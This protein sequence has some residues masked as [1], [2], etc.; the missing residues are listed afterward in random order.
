MSN[1]ILKYLL[2]ICIPLLS[3][4]HTGDESLYSYHTQDKSHYSVDNQI[5]Q[6]YFSSA[7]DDSGNSIKA[8][9]IEESE[10]ENRISSLLKKVLKN[11]NYFTTVFQ[12]KKYYTCDK[13]GSSP[14][15]EYISCFSF[16]SPDLHLVFRVIRI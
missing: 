7:I 2:F 13:I 4:V 15:D 11:G 5:E 12:S 3:Y 6:A 14:N 9:K 16:Y 8:T 1:F 10:E